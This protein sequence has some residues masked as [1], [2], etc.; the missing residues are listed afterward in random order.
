[1]V[2]EPTKKPK[3]IYDL[4]QDDKE[5]LILTYLRHFDSLSSSNILNLFG[6][7]PLI[8]KATLYRKISVLLKKKWI[9]ID[10]VKTAEKSGKYYRVTAMIE[11][12]YNQKDQLIEEAKENFERELKIDPKD[13]MRN[14]ANGFQSLS[15]LNQ[16]L[17]DLYQL[18]PLED[19]KNSQILLKAQASLIELDVTNE[20]WKDIQAIITEFIQKL[21]IYG[22]K[23]QR[24]GDH[25]FNVFFS[26]LPLHK[27]SMKNF[28]ET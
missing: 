22:S 2:D 4:C 10:P 27:M 13:V 8:S 14:F 7:P 19:A 28:L 21:E 24:K 23:Q 26:I 9:E 11:A 12:V 5:F 15:A 1:M 6:S 17:F 18:N 3:F 25:L 16:G 20:N